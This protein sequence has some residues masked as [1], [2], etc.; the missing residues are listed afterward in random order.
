MYW[1]YSTC[2]RTRCTVAVVLL[3]VGTSRAVIC[4]IE[5]V[6]TIKSNVTFVLQGFLVELFFIIFTSYLCCKRVAKLRTDW[7]Q[8]TLVEERKLVT[9]T[10]PKCW[11]LLPPGK[12]PI[13]HTYKNQSM[14][15]NEKQSS[16][17]TYNGCIFSVDNVGIQTGNWVLY[18]ICKPVLAVHWCDQTF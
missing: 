16:A 4:N 2:K 12:L 17:Y 7:K 11:T 6:L 13:L 10:R 3:Y 1:N 8:K 14:F 9:C 15:I 5:Q 18:I